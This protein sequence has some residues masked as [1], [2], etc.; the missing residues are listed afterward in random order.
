MKSRIIILFTTRDGWANEVDTIQYA[1]TGADNISDCVCNAGYYKYGAHPHVCLNC[2]ADSYCPGNN[3]QYE[4]PQNSEAAVNSAAKE[5]C[6]CKPGFWRDSNTTDWCDV[7]PAGSYK[8]ELGFQPCTVC[9]LHTFNEDTASTA[10]TDCNNCPSNSSSV[11]L[12][13]TYENRDHHNDCQ[14]HHGY[15]TLDSNGIRI[16]LACLKGYYD[17]RSSNNNTCLPCPVNTY[18]AAVASYVCTPCGGNSVTDGTH[19]TSITDCLCVAGHK[20]ESDQ[21]VACDAGSYQPSVLG[22]VECQFCPNNT[23]SSRGASSC[24]LCHNQSVSDMQ[25]ESIEDCLCVVGTEHVVTDTTRQCDLCDPGFFKSST[26]NSACTG[27]PSGTY[28][29]NAG[30]SACSLCPSDTYSYN[31]DPSVIGVSTCLA[32]PAFSSSDEGADSVNDCLCT[33]GHKWI[34]DACVPCSIGFFKNSSHVYQTHN[35]D[36]CHACP[37]GKST[38]F[39]G[40]TSDEDCY[41]CAADKYVNFNGS[42]I[43][44]PS[45]SISAEGSVGVAS[46]TCQ[47]GF[48]AYDMI[49]EI[50]SE[51]VPCGEGKYKSEAGNHHCTS[52]PAGK[53]ARTESEYLDP[54]IYGTVWIDPLGV[55]ETGSCLD[56]E[57]NT[58]WNNGTCTACPAN[59]LAETGSVS[60]TD[61]VCVAGFE[62]D[63]RS[64]ICTEC[65]AGTF[66]ANIGNDHCQ[67]CTEG[68]YAAQPTSTV[69]TACSPHSSTISSGAAQQT[70]CVCNA[71][72]FGLPGSSCTVCP[73]GTFSSINQAECT[74]CGTTHYLPLTALGTEDVCTICPGHSSV[75][76]PPGSG[77]ASC[78]CDLG[79]VRV[80]NI[81]CV[82]VQNTLEHLVKNSPRRKQIL[83]VSNEELL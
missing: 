5:D 47:Y 53:R 24:T 59:T 64:H 72:Y 39:T 44:C 1:P 14:C 79:F 45:N 67:Q 43:H 68:T 55:T 6:F 51:C 4:C 7:C 25:S 10:V 69:C 63:A 42:C 28:A 76:Q 13:Q 41:T 30:M 73:T 46:C 18:S 19:K 23:F 77:I 16:C 65:V 80:S 20:R 49:L 3:M 35:E 8:H 22:G 21:C 27:C 75:R 57:A 29:P 61:C 62:F 32:C 82:F 70:D 2:P 71:G 40:S 31:S 81:S 83:K 9:P 74:T 66:K 15:E 60:I 48:T 52:C 12:T 34:T 33:E 56:C 11:N 50:N 37:V 26:S 38:L 36:S 58:F 17:G 78:V 54:V